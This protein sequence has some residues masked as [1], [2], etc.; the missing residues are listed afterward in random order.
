MG[1]KK[2]LE[3]V[4]ESEITVQV[5]LP[6]SFVSSFKDGEEIPVTTRVLIPGKF[7]TRSAAAKESDPKAVKSKQVPVN[8]EIH[9]LS[10]LR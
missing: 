3:G 10:S 4:N 5:F 7:N 8:I 1:E 2:P 9:K 6:D